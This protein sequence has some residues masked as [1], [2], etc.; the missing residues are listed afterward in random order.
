MSNPPSNNIIKDL[1]KYVLAL[2]SSLLPFVWVVKYAA[3]LES[4]EKQL[5][6]SII[7]LCST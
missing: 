1:A 5:A 2:Y 6:G 7:L 4:K 3:I